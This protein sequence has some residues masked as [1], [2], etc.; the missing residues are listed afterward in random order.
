MIE[1]VNHHMC[2]HYHDKN[3]H[4]IK[5]GLVIIIEDGQYHYPLMPAHGEM[6]ERLSF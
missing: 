6:Q 1:H 3:M 2:C 5:D 4:N